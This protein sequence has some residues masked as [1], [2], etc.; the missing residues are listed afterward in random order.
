MES[1]RNLF[2]T[3]GDHSLKSSARSA[4]IQEED[5]VVDVSHCPM[6]KTL[7]EGAIRKVPFRGVR[8]ESF[9]ER[10]FAGIDRETF[11]RQKK[12]QLSRSIQD[13]QE[14]QRLLD[15]ILKNHEVLKTRQGG[16]YAKETLE[17]VGASANLKTSG[18]TKSG[19]PTRAPDHRSGNANVNEAKGNS[20][21]QAPSAGSL[22]GLEDLLSNLRIG[23]DESG[24]DSDSTR[25]GADSPDSEKSA[26]P[27]SLKPR[28][29]SISSD[30]YRGVDSSLSGGVPRKED[31]STESETR[32]SKIEKVGA[33]N[34]AVVAAAN[35]PAFDDS[36]ATQST[37]LMSEEDDDTDSCDEDTFADFLEYQPDLT[38]VYSKTEADLLSKS[39]ETLMKA[40]TATSALL[41]E[42]L[43]KLQVTDRDDLD[44]T[45]QCDD[46]DARGTDDDVKMKVDADERKLGVTSE[47]HVNVSQAAKFQNL[48]KDK[49]SKNRK[50]SSPS[51][52]H[53]L[54]HAAS[55]CQDSPPANKIHSLSDAMINPLRYY[56]PKRSRSTLELDTLDVP[57]N[58][59]KKMLTVDQSLVPVAS[60]PKPATAVNKILV[61]RELKTMKL[62]VKHPAGLGISVERCE[63]ARPF[64][65]IAKM[66]LNGEAAKSK[67]F[68]IGDEIVRI[69][70]RRIRGMSMV[71]A[72][73]TLRS[74]VGTVELQI[75][76]E[77]NPAFGEEIGDTWGNAL[78]RT[79]SDPDAWLSKN[80]RVQLSVASG[81]TSSSTNAGIPCA[82]DS[83][84][85]S[86][87][88]MTGMKKFQV[89]RKRSA[90]APTVRR[91]SSLSIDL[92]TIML[93]KG[94]PKK[95]GFSIVGGVDSNKGRMGIFVKDIMLGGQA[96]DEG[97][98][99]FLFFL[100]FSAKQY[101]YL[102]NIKLN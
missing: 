81:G 39:R 74:C 32:G 67:Q 51:V 92:L 20:C 96:A 16:S 45:P 84:T 83:A 62:T 15:Y 27:A 58:A 72:R 50:C 34:A 33:A 88:K 38:R 2:R 64:Y 60:V 85:A 97:T 80:K 23:C 89:V 10:E 52:L 94:V 79:R 87:Q 93:E 42:D 86:L 21:P 7:S 5:A 70:G 25:A 59:T 65:V 95:L 37:V 44:V 35:N 8:P 6:G 26:V 55:P 47:N 19:S 73:N 69:C 31:A 63:A 29:C 12:L 54:D 4:T 91:G 22:T 11:L 100:F 71:E 43:T 66:D 36:T 13:L 1:L 76:R 90:E 14:Q 99:F 24:Y 53:L 30:D 77:P 57:R 28:R 101:L 61:R 98:V 102:R 49:K 56:N 82:V 41:G 40:A 18:E 48:L 17:N 68:R 9:D 3:G 46:A 75:A 78:T